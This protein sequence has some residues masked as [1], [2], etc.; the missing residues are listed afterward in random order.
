MKFMGHW[1][2]CSTSPNVATLL[3]ESLQAIKRAFIIFA[4]NLTWSV[5]FSYSDNRK[6]FTPIYQSLLLIT[7]PLHQQKCADMVYP[8]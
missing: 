8:I 4:S 6:V 7:R 5:F 1:L 3:T 2:R